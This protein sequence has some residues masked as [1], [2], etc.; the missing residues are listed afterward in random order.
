MQKEKHP[1][2]ML[3]RVVCLTFVGIGIVLAGYSLATS[4]SEDAMVAA[5]YVYIPLLVSGLLGL[6]FNRRGGLGITLLVNFLIMAGVLGVL[7]A[8]YEVLWPIL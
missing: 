3:A 1:T 6:P 5:S 4:N 8:F 7:L 2:M